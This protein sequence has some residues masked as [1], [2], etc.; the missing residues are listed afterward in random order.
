MQSMY[1]PIS[2]NM[3]VLQKV[4][5]EYETFP[6]WKTDTSAARK[7]NDLPVKAQNYIRFVENHIGVPSTLSTKNI[8]LNCLAKHIIC[9]LFCFFLLFKK[10]WIE[11]GKSISE[12]Y[13]SKCPVLTLT[14]FQYWLY[15][16][17]NNNVLDFCIYS[18]CVLVFVF[19]SFK[20]SGLVLE[21]P[22]S[23]WSRCSKGKTIFFDRSPVWNDVATFHLQNYV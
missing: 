22:E 21:S 7:W 1:C 2:A 11:M 10:R 19:L 4:E 15:F 13:Y 6:G 18:T 8:H 12:L 17:I 23:A 14:N 3:D 20:S 5:V 16:I 9:F